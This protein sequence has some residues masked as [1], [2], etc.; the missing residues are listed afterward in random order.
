[1]ADSM[2]GM[3]ALARLKRLGNEWEQRPQI[4]ADA[5]AEK[6]TWQEIADALHMTPHG[7]RKLYNA[8]RSEDHNGPE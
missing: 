2:E 4:I 3:S 5:R 8:A 7:A 1:M 6:A